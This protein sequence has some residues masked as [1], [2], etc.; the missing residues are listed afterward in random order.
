M[1]IDTA[2]KQSSM[3]NM[4]C[5]LS[6]NL[7]PTPDGAYNERDRQHLLGLYRGIAFFGEGLNLEYQAPGWFMPLPKREVVGY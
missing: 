1:A 6:F 3:L 5:G 7:L 4:V 2:A